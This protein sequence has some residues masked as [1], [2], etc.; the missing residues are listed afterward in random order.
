[1]GSDQT[2]C[3]QNVD[4]LPSRYLAL[5]ATTYQDPC[6]RYGGTFIDKDDKLITLPCGEEEVTST[7]FS[8]IKA[9][10]QGY[11]AAR[12]A[13]KKVVDPH[14]EVAIETSDLTHFPLMDTGATN[15]LGLYSFFRKNVIHFKQRFT[16]T[17]NQQVLWAMGRRRSRSRATST[18][19]YGSEPRMV[20]WNVFRKFIC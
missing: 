10:I 2:H 7:L 13:D 5:Q 20:L 15:V 17:P 6:G 19:H 9:Q 12:R 14:V 8:S 16:P 3:V 11:F 1:M 18:L 4:V